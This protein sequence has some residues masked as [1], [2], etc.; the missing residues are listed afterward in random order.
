M[1]KGFPFNYFPLQ[2]FHITLKE[3]I[4]MTANLILMIAGLLFLLVALV[5]VY[6]WIGKSKPIPLT[7]QPQKIETF[8]SLSEI[9]KN[10]SSSSSDLNHAVEIILSRF[11]HI[12]SHTLSKYQHL[13]EALCTH[14]YTDSK[15]ILRFEKT[16]RTANPDYTHEIEKALSIGLASRG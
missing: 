3:I 15:L 11:G 12:N 8:E 16:L 9:I 1:R 5:V 10:R 6:I 4:M 7:A 14:P 13:L 2:Y